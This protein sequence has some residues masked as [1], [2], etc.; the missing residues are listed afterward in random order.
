M[1]QSDTLLLVYLFEIFRNMC[2]EIYELNP[3]TAGLAWQALLKK[4]KQN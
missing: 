3:W 4:W 2:I 1:I